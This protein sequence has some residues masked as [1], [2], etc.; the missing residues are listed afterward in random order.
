MVIG[1]P[2]RGVASDRLHFCSEHAQAATRDSI[3]ATI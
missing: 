1:C 3:Y 2:Q